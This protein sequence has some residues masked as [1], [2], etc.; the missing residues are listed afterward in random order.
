MKTRCCTSLLYSTPRGLLPRGEGAS[1]QG[2]G[3][4]TRTP[5]PLLAKQV[6]CQL[7]HAPRCPAQA[8][9]RCHFTGSVTSAHRA[10][11]A[12]SDSRLRHTTK[13]AAATSARTNSFFTRFLLGWRPRRA[14]S[15]GELPRHADVEPTPAAEDGGGAELNPENH[16]PRARGQVLGGFRRG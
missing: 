5:N 13:P 1:D 6:R 14:A 7:R 11:S 15:R 4:G 2:G 3:E 12:R 9:R 8:G 16:A 10:C